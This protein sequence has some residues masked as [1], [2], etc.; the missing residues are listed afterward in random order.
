MSCRSARKARRTAGIGAIAK[1]VDACGLAGEIDAS[2]DLLKLH[3]PY[4]ES[5]NVLNR[6]RRSLIR[7][8]AGGC[9]V[10]FAIV[11]PEGRG[12][13]NALVRALVT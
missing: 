11:R 6:A 12:R 3:K 2:L 4:Y 10:A 5:D 9:V 1:L 8:G 7:A 13:A